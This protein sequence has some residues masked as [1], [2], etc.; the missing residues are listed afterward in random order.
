MQNQKSVATFVYRNTIIVYNVKLK[1]RNVMAVVN[2]NDLVLTDK[3]AL[4]AK[5]DLTPGGDQKPEDKTGDSNLQ[6][7]NPEDPNNSKPED[8]NNNGGEGNN[9]NEE[10][11]EAGTE[12]ETTDGNFVVDENGNLVDAEGNVF[13][14]AKDVK[15]YLDG[16]SQADDSELNIE[17]LQHLFDVE[18]F[19]ENGHAVEYADTPEG[20]KAYIDKVIELKQQEAEGVALANFFKQ[21]PIVG[22]F[23]KFVAAGGNPSDF[24]NIVDRRGV[25]FDPENIELC[26]D[27][28]REAWEE[29]GRRGD[30][31]GY[32]SYLESGGS[33]IDVAKQ[34]LEGL[35]KRDADAEAERTARA[36]E[37]AEQ[38]KKE[39][40]ETVNDIYNRINSGVIGIYKIPEVI[41]V[42]RDG[43]KSSYS[44]K[45]FFNYLV[46]TDKDGRTAFDKDL[47]NKTQDERANKFLIDAYLT[48][49]GGS[50]KT[51]VD[52]AVK[53]NEVKK[54][55]F[56]AKKAAAKSGGSPIIKKPAS[57]SINVN[58]LIF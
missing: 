13:K 9:G 47:E 5:T 48:F 3:D 6:N 23:Y 45:D 55:R 46:K 27:I 30:V 54:L 44:R 41:S 4:E 19:D 29:D 40:E 16:F 31:E 53:E 42:E 28:I 24:G 11:L 8:N 36:K 33:L 37:I 51:L 50:Y 39:Y 34:E 1:Q 15:S 21:N 17:N 52:M 10:T 7:Q 26:K 35:Q 58:D 57:K 32:I 22:N 56:T 25:K 43:K 49:T 18:V 14:E 2:V 20:H 38:N 12:V